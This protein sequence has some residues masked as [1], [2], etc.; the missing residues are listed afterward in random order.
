[1]NTLQRYLSIYAR[2]LLN[3]FLFFFQS[4]R[5]FYYDLLHNFEWNLR[6]I[7]MI[8]FC[9][10]HHLNHCNWMKKLLSF[11]ASF[12]QILVLVVPFVAALQNKQTNKQKTIMNKI[13]YLFVNAVIRNMSM[14]ASFWLS[15]L[16][17]QCL[18][19]KWLY[20]GLGDLISNLS[21]RHTGNGAN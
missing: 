12:W 2:E 17:G 19:T 20:W 1:M 8:F 14:F 4:R 5:I 6:I 10:Y 9:I 7:K 21:Y 11:D 3:I 18:W 16:R 13:K 15:Q